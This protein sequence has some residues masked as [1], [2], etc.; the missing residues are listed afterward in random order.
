SILP[1]IQEG[2]LRA[3]AVAGKKRIGSLP[4]VPSMAEAGLP[5]VEVSS[6]VGIVAPAGTPPETVEILNKEIAAIIAAPEFHQRMAAIG[7]DV[8]GTT[9]AEYAKILRDD[10][11]K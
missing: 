11:A 8:L 4:D 6:A 5:N 7:V 9:P 10:Y 3:L 2:K 1:L